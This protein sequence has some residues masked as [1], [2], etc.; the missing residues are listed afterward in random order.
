M[1]LQRMGFYYKSTSYK[2]MSSSDKEIR[3]LKVQH[4]ALQNKLI[5]RNNSNKSKKR[6]KRG[7]KLK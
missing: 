7:E 5:T 1:I 6:S 4:N 3:E 2:T